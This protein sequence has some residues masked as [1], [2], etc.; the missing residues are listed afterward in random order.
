[1]LVED[2]AKDPNLHDPRLPYAR[3]FFSLGNPEKVRAI[4]V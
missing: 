4:L 3:F 1:V 2:H